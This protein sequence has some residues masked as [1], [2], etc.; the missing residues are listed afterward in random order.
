MSDS[1]TA[2]TSVRQV[3]LS[4]TNSRSLLKLMSIMPV[5]SSNHLIL[6]HPLLLLPSI[7]PSIRVFSNE[8]VLHIRWPKYWSLSFSIINF[9]NTSIHKYLCC[10]LENQNSMYISLYKVSIFCMRAELCPILC[11][12]MDCSPPGPSAM[13]FLRQEH[14]RGLSLPPSGDLSDPGVKPCLLHWQADSLPLRHYTGSTHRE[15]GGNRTVTE[16][17][18]S[19]NLPFHFNNL[20]LLK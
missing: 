18:S 17:D 4:I 13:E 6:C 20:L 1:A 2:W 14:W 10:Y 16:A 8:S 9:P 15:Y 12:A 5:M 3:S 7:S 11:D 19:I